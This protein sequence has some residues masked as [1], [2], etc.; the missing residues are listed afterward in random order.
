MADRQRCAWIKDELMAT[1][2]DEEW[3]VPLH[4]DRKHFEF[5]ILDAMQA[6]LSWKTVLQKRKNFRAAF[7]KFDPGKVARYGKRKVNELLGNAGIIRNRQK[8]HAAI[9]NARAF[10]AV[11]QECGTFDR[12]IWQF[13]GGRTIVNAWDSLKKLPARSAESDAMSKALKD[14][15]FSFVGSTICYSYMQAAGMI[16]DHVVHC[17]RYDE[18]RRLAVGQA[19]SLP[20]S[21]YAC[22][23]LTRRRRMTEASWQLALRANHDQSE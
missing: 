9:Q 1:Y 6:G 7:D 20:L 5:I 21:S 10:L 19:A 2:H 13:T 4:N 14:R 3:G 12:Y 15:G 18:I 23:N 22:V 11:Q 16:N 17:F 8:I